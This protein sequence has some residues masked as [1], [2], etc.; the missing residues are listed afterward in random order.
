MLKVF[1]A[2]GTN[3]SSRY[4][5]AARPMKRVHVLAGRQSQGIYRIKHSSN[6]QS[7]SSNMGNCIQPMEADQT[8]DAIMIKDLMNVIVHLTQE[9]NSKTRDLEM[10]RHQVN[11]F[12]QEVENRDREIAILKTELRNNMLKLKK[13][14]FTV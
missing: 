10:Y 5:V 8:S 13:V 1:N 6:H 2:P 9:L 7:V 14:C 12:L 11:V 4:S 3:S